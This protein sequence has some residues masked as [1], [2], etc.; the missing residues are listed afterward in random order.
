MGAAGESKWTSLGVGQ[1]EAV[2]PVIAYVLPVG[3]A[4][5][6][7]GD[8]EARDVLR[9]L[10]PNLGGEAQ[11]QR[12]AMLASEWRVVHLVARQRLRMERRCHVERLVVVIGAFERQEPCGRVGADQRQHLL[13]P[14]AAD[15]ADDIPAFDADVPGVL[16]NSWQCVYLL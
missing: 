7:V 16:S 11:P 1:L 10:V 12:R 9:R 2:E 3:A 4:L 5:Q 6:D 13:Q 14:R 8:S 15:A